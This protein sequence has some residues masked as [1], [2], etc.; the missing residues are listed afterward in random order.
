MDTDK[1]NLF[2]LDEEENWKRENEN[3]IDRCVIGAFFQIS[4]LIIQHFITALNIPLETV[5]TIS[6]YRRKNISN[7]WTGDDA[8]AFR[9]ISFEF[10]WRETSFQVKFI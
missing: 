7:V 6:S 5:H 3:K 1:W 8:C 2:K 10:W 9:F 4:G